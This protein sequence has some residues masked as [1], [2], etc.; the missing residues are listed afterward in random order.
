M[1]LLARVEKL[2]KSLARQEKARDQAESAA[3]QAEERAAASEAREVNMLGTIDNL[4]KQ[5]EQLTKAVAG[6]NREMKEAT[7]AIRAD[8]VDIRSQLEAAAD[9]GDEADVSDAEQDKA[10]A[11]RNRKPRARPSGQRNVGAADRKKKKKKNG[12]G[13]SRQA[14]NQ[15]HSCARLALAKARGTDQ[16]KMG[17]DQLPAWQPGALFDYSPPPSHERNKAGLKRALTYAQT[18]RK[19]WGALEDDKIFGGISKAIDS[20]FDTL[21]RRFKKQALPQD[22]KELHQAEHRRQERK[23]RKAAR[24]VAVLLVLWASEQRA[25]FGLDFLDPNLFCLEEIQDLLQV[26]LMSSEVSDG[27]PESA[28]GEDEE[29]AGSEADEG[30]NGGKKKKVARRTYG[31]R[32]GHFS[33]LLDVLDDPVVR[34]SD[35]EAVHSDDAGQRKPAKLPRLRAQ[36]VLEIPSVA[37]WEHLAPEVSLALLNQGVPIEKYWRAKTVAGAPDSPTDPERYGHDGLLGWLRMAD[38]EPDARYGGGGEGAAGEGEGEERGVDGDEFE[39]GGED[40]AQIDGAEAAGA[41]AEQQGPAEDEWEQWL[42]PELRG[43]EVTPAVGA[44]D[45]NDDDDDDDL[46]SPQS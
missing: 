26:E 17:T 21:R 20:S 46:Y 34:D 12:E 24:R 7:S 4:K 11:D 30:N 38:V 1:E 29:N 36:P 8:I 5:V 40:G 23:R 2:E 44:G 3:R 6:S 32:S 14:Q 19:H 41:D 9:S 42:A 35:G 37:S 22:K 45:V 10:G 33:R 25:E 15:L 27:E 39:V 28:N 16:S 13:V 31:Y 43:A 18:N